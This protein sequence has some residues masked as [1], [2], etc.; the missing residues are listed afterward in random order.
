[1][2]RIV[3]ATSPTTDEEYGG[4]TATQAS[5]VAYDNTTSGL[6]ADD[7]QEAID[8]V[9]AKTDAKLSDVHMNFVRVTNANLT[10]N[11]DL[12]SYVD[13]ALSPG[14]SFIG[15]LSMG[16]SDSWV[17]NFPI[18]VSQASSKEGR[19]WW[20]GTIPTNGSVRFY[21]LEQKVG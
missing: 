13:N 6:T 15:F 8:E 11:M 14:Y 9:D 10:T 16:S 19:P 2:G 12:T 5:E 20:S 7:V 3:L 1:M 21:F 18:Y 4:T 17:T